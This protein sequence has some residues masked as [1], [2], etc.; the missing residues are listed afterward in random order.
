M[1]QHDD[2]PSIAAQIHSAW[3]SGRICSLVGRGARARVL[4]LTR[5]VEQGHISHDAALRLARETEAV[6]FCLAPLPPG[7][8]P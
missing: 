7:D 2:L 6:A 4:R 8:E 1:T 3:L 5:L